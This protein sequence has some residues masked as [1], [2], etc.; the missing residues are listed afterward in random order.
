MITLT[1]AEEDALIEVG[2]IGMSKAAKQLSIL[3]KSSIKITIPTISLINIDAL[4]DNHANDKILSFVYQTLSGDLYGCAALVFQREQTRLLTSPII[5]EIPQ[6]T[7]KEVR[8][9]EQEA[10]LEIANII[11]S[12]C[13]S[14]INNMLT[15]KVTLGLPTYDENNLVSLI[16]NLSEA[17]DKLSKNVLTIATQLN[18]SDDELSGQLYIILNEDSV[19]SL[20]AGIKV[21]L[22]GSR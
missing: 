14:A 22:N 20:L 18:A 10:L 2:N 4:I 7:E 5:G 8:A 12:S 11:I 15:K 1:S 21:L 19:K 17:M 6:L 9:C 3:L 16:K 13:M